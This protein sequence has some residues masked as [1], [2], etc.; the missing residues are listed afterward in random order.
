[1]TGRS[2]SC[3]LAE[4]PPAAAAPA[5]ATAA[6]PAGIAGVLHRLAGRLAGG[7]LFGF[8]PLLV[9]L[10]GAIKALLLLLGEM[11]HPGVLVQA[12]LGERLGDLAHHPAGAAEKREPTPAKPAPRA[13][14][15]APAAR[16]APA[17]TPL[18]HH[19][20]GD[21]A[22]NRRGEQEHSGRAGRSGAHDHLLE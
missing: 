16:I 12:L 17:A 21:H 9:G 5:S 4:S 8:H 6:I 22:R 14:L 15:A 11:E 1:M 19:G 7:I 2:F 10:V 20:G 13:A 3:I 18:G